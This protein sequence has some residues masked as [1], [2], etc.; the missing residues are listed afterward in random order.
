MKLYLNYQIYNIVLKSFNEYIWILIDLL[1]YP[2]KDI[3]PRDKFV[4]IQ[5]KIYLCIVIKKYEY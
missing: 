4:Y 5:K 3:F 2:D 1:N